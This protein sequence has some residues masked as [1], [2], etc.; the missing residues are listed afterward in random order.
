MEVGAS[1]KYDVELYYTC[2]Q[3]D[4]GSTI[5][6]RFGGSRL[7]GQITEAHDPPLRGGENDR[8]R[9]EVRKAGYLFGLGT[10]EA[11]SFKRSELLSLPSMLV[12]ADMTTEDVLVFLE[13]EEE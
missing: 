12:K 13:G 7:R 8:V 3:K 9:E 10:Q 11:E 4:V 6:L 5:E 2:P 1:G